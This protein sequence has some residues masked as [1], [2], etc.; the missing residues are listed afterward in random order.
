MSRELLLGALSA[1]LIAGVLAGCSADATSSAGAW[2]SGGGYAS[3][4]GGTGSS[5][6]ADSSQPILADID[7]NGTLIATPGQ[8][9]GVYV[10]YESGGHWTIAWTCD[11][12]IT[13]L[14]CSYTVAASVG[15]NKLTD[16]PGTIENVGGTVA[17]ITDVTSSTGATIQASSLTTSATDSMTFD[18]APGATITVT[19]QLNGPVSFFFVQD[20]KV[21]GGYTGSLT[22][23]MLFQPSSD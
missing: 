17:G 14:S 23:P 4:S 22:N 19:V 18:T 5:S 9:L 1:G 15:V 13:N 10:T 16:A 12:A 6:G 3:S 20:S 8:G 2:S 21:N 7:T 11:T